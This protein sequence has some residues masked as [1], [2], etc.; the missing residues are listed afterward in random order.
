M[1]RVVKRHNLLIVGSET[2]ERPEKEQI[3]DF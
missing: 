3:G 2:S 1:R